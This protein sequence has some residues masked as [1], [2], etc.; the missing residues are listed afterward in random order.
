MSRSPREQVGSVSHLIHFQAIS[1]EQLGCHGSANEIVKVLCDLKSSVGL[2]HE[3]FPRRDIVD[4]YLHSSRFAWH[5][6]T[7]QTPFPTTWEKALMEQLN[8]TCSWRVSTLI[9][10]L[11][12]GKEHYEV[13]SDEWLTLFILGGFSVACFVD[14]VMRIVRRDIVDTYLHASWIWCHYSAKQCLFPNTWRESW[15]R[16]NDLWMLVLL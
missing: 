15:K 16:L 13:L 3:K 14:L 5:Y 11:V 12:N 2:S 4:T 6:R 1:G 10:G 9:L 8:Q 7:K